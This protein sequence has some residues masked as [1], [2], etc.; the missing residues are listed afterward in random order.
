MADDL[1]ALTAKIDA[2]LPPRYQGCF[3]RVRPASMGTAP[4][5][6]SA[7]GK[8]A[9][10]EIWTTFCDL[11]LAGGPPHR[12][13]LL[14]P[15]AEE[16]AG[17][18]PEKYRA[19]VAEIERAIRLTT[20][21]VV[22]PSPS[23]G[24][25]GVRCASAAMALWLVR[26]IVVENVSAR[27]DETILYLPAGPSYRLGKEIKNVVTSLAKTCH[28]WLDHMSAGQRSAAT[29]EHPL[30]E[31]ASAAEV[32]AAPEEYR[33]IAA[34][35]ARLVDSCAGLPTI[36]SAALG[37]VG[38]RCADQEMAVWLQRA[39]LVENVLVRREADTLYLPARPSYGAAEMEQLARALTQARQGWDLWMKGSSHTCTGFPS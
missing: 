35:V 22:V 10:D 34:E 12:G 14:E 6:F 29:A 1:Q 25:V 8:V 27:R 21:L 13:T 30:L 23:P 32:E 4:L 39:I 7:D 19:V 2:M 11:A 20:D 33:T 28:Y 18:E 36:P 38:A 9:W 17:A 37:W 24:W 15:V 26:A 5:K 3:E 31:A 16:E